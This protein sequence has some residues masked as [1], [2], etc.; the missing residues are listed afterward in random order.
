MTNLQMLAERN[1]S[2]GTWKNQKGEDHIS[3]S[4][5]SGKYHKNIAI[6]VELIPTVIA[7]FEAKLAELKK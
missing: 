5:N 2:V 4:R 7:E 1:L 6:P 3:L